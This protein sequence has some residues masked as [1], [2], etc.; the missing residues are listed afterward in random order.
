MH[1]YRIKYKEKIP[2][3]SNRRRVALQLKPLYWNNRQTPNDWYWFENKIE[4]KEVPEP[5]DYCVDVI[6][7]DKLLEGGAWFAPIIMKLRPNK[8]IDA[9]LYL[10]GN[11][12]DNWV[13]IYSKFP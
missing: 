4:L 5:H 7:S 10:Q 13:T 12:E 3:I 1:T 2:N 8:D 6:C 11:I 9:I